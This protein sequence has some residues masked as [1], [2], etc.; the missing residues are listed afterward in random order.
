MV[1]ILMALDFGFNLVLGI[2]VLVLANQVLS[3][4]VGIRSWQLAFIPLFFMI[5]VW[6][7][8]QT[9][10]TSFI[11]MAFIKRLVLVRPILLLR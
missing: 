3:K 10:A 9:V 7:R 2:L 11:L 8:N 6:M 5:I 4:I 1:L